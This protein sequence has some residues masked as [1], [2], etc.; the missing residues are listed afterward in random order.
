VPFWC[1]LSACLLAT[2]CS[3]LLS[4]LPSSPPFP[5]LVAT[6]SCSLDAHS[7]YACLRESTF[8][9]LIW[10]HPVLSY[11]KGLSNLWYFSVLLRSKNNHLPSCFKKEERETQLGRGLTA[12]LLWEKWGSDSTV[13]MKVVAVLYSSLNLDETMAGFN[14]YW[15]LTTVPWKQG[16]IFLSLP[17]GCWNPKRLGM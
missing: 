4:T 17:W 3:G 2:V 6:F 7:S 14:W 1:P 12:S 16:N 15:M 5:Y 11:M 9:S 13:M 10:G 8:F